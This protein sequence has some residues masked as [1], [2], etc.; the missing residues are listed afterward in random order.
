ME[1]AIITPESIVKKLASVPSDKLQEIDLFIQFIIYQS[2][3]KTENL[4]GKGN[5]KFGFGK[6]LIRF[7]ADDFNAPMEDFKEYME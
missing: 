4:S 5:R 3:N 2:N 1:T 6:N 7:V